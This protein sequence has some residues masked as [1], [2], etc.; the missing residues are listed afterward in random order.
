MTHLINEW[1]NII[2]SFCAPNQCYTYPSIGSNCKLK[3]IHFLLSLANDTFSESLF[4][5]FSVNFVVCLNQFSLNA[6]M[7]LIFCSKLQWFYHDQLGYLFLF[8]FFNLIIVGVLYSLINIIPRNRVV[9]VF[10]TKGIR[11]SRCRIIFSAL[12]N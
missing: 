1:R 3:Y 12:T 10:L 7:C 9:I 5:E 11:G 8:C 2:C 6:I 4:E